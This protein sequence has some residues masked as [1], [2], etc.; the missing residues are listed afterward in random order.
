MT[1]NLLR[2]PATDEKDFLS[3]TRILTALNKVGNHYKRT[4]FH[5]D[6]RRLLDEFVNCLLSTVASGSLIGLWAFREKVDKR[7]RS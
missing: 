1:A 6:A 3:G 4:E 5:R 7:E 2:F